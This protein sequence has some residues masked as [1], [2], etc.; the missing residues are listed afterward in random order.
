MHVSVGQELRDYVRDPREGYAFI[1][2]LRN[3]GKEAVRERE[4][5]ARQSIIRNV[6]STSTSNNFT[7]A[8]LL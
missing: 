7:R 1:Y 8:T 6:Y 2:A 4:E 5:N 3:C